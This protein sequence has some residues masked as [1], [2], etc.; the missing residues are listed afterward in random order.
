MSTGPLRSH[1][2]GRAFQS[3]RNATGNAEIEAAWRAF[4]TALAAR[5]DFFHSQLP[6]TIR[7]AI[8]GAGQVWMEARRAADFTPVVMKLGLLQEMFD[9]ADSSTANQRV[10]EELR[11][12]LDYIS[13]SRGLLAAEETGDSLLVGHAC[14]K[15][16]V[17]SSPFGDAPSLKDLETRRVAAVHRLEEIATN[18]WNEM[19]DRLPRA[20]NPADVREILE[21]IRAG[22]EANAGVG[23]ALAR[24]PGQRFADAESFVIDWQEMLTLAVTRQ[25]FAAAE[26]ARALRARAE[27]SIPTLVPILAEKEKEALQ[28]DR[29]SVTDRIL[30]QQAGLCERLSKAS[31]VGELQRVLVDLHYL[32]IGRRGDNPEEKAVLNAIDALEQLAAAWTAIDA[33]TSEGAAAQLAPPITAGPPWAAAISQVRDRLQRQLLAER[34]SRP[35]LL[36]PPLNAHSTSE[37]LSTLRRSAQERAD[38]R[39]VYALLNAQAALGLGAHPDVDL[40]AVRAFLVAE[41]FEKAEQPTDAVVHYKEALQ[42]VGLTELVASATKRI[43]ALSGRERKPTRRA[44]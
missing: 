33:Q 23:V 37:V 26:A 5:R 10:R 36:Q 4:D 9:A 13:N 16:R 25:W 19:V 18:A 20:A 3:P 32:L 41:N 31:D 39:E 12:A 17:Y 29:Q 35:D 2:V 34:L 11:G 38:W 28:N 8:N 42:A 43:K 1:L 27:T 24:Q 22:A 6:K 14:A 30:A 40:A 21:K 7:S 44:Q 15:L